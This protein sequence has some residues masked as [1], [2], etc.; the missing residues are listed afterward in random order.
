MRPISRYWYGTYR[1]SGGSFAG[2]KFPA[3]MPDCNFRAEIVVAE[4]GGVSGT[5]ADEMGYDRPAVLEGS[6]DGVTLRFIKYYAHQIGPTGQPAHPI[7]YIG[8]L[9]DDGTMLS[10]TWIINAKSLFIIPVTTEG[11]WQ[12]MPYMPAM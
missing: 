6:F 11:I 10:G 12:A 4:N 9:S 7:E 8:T 3:S 5:I 2:L 1:Y